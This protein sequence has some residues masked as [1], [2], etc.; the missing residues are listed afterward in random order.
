MTFGAMSGGSNPPPRTLSVTNTGGGTLSWTATADQPWLTLN[1]AAGNAP[2]SISVT[3]VTAGLAPGTYN[4]AITLTA[5]GV[6]G[7]P[8]VVPVSVSVFSLADSGLLTVAVLVDASNPQGYDVNPTSPGEFQRYPERYLEH[9]QVPYEVIDVATASPPSDLPQRHLIVAGHRGLNLSAAWRNAIV[10]AVNGGAGFVNLDWDPQIGS[11]SHIQTIFGTTG[12]SVGA[13]ATTIVVPESVIPGGSS[14]HYIAALQRRF[15]D[16]PAGDLVYRFHDDANDQE[17]PV[18]STI[19]NGAS[20]TVIA[21]AGSAPLILARSFGSGRAVH[22]GTLEYLKADRFGF[23]QGVD[24]LFWRSLVWAARKPF[25]VRG[26]PRLWAIQMDDTKEGWASRVRDMYDPAVTGTAGADGSGGPWKVT[27]YTYLFAS[28]PAG[29]PDRASAI[30]DVN[31][32]RLR[33]SPHAFNQVADGDLYWNGSSGPLSDQQW[34]N[35][36]ATLESWRQGIGGTDT[37]SSF[38]RSM[39]PHFWNL[40]NNTGFDLWNTLGFRYVTSLQ[41]PGYQL[42]V[43]DPVD[44]HGGQE[45][46]NARPFWVYEKP[47]KRSR[48]ESQPFFFADDLPVGSRAGLPPKTLFLFATQVQGMGDLRPDL[49]WPNSSIPWTVNDSIDQF[50]RHTWRFWSSLAPIQ[51]FTHDASNY[52]LSTVAERRAVI[53]Q[54]SSWLRGQGAKHVFQ[55]DMGDYIYARSKS[56]LVGAVLSGG[57]ITFIFSGNAATADGALVN[58]HVLLFVGDDEGTLR[59]IPGFVGGANVAVP[60]VGP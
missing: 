55:D 32:G 39:V 20:G 40:S 50:Q 44:V 37:I 45:R 18:V 29:S 38:S 3:I 17:Q 27:G 1:P 23:L 10:S 51:V 34:L 15:Q 42:Q 46:P 59:E 47:P 54:L 31:A 57:S 4:G 60:V 21:S 35:N 8:Q 33:L 58:T 49:T 14:P 41:K 11:L 16:T 56:T 19:L 53:S 30:A 25:V 22:V 7:S 9:L 28:L 24:D 52:E 13:P 6:A 26:Y 2:G 12:S 36:L 48:D 43:S 5:A